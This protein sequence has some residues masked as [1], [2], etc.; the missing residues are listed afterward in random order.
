MKEPLHFLS[1]NEN[2]NAQNLQISSRRYVLSEYRAI[3]KSTFKQTNFNY[4]NNFRANDFSQSF[5]AFPS[6]LPNKGI[7]HAIKEVVG[8]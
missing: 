3:K 6:D 7:I 5:R 1:K 4:F 2:C 8:E